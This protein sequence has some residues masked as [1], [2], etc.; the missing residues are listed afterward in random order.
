MFKRKRKA[1]NS[2]SGYEKIPDTE[3]EQEDEQYE[4]DSPDLSQDSPIVPASTE[5]VP[6]YV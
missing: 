6:K 1:V 5:E 4:P 3:E 2:P